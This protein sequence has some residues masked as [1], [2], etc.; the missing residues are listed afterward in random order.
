[1]AET[2]AERAAALYETMKVE[3]VAEARKYCLAHTPMDLQTDMLPLVDADFP[4]PAPEPPP[5]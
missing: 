4:E 3:A 5:V 1:M 2:T